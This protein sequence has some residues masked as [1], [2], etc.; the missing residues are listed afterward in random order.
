ML[1]IPAHAEGAG[2]SPLVARHSSYFR[3]GLGVPDHFLGIEELQV[4]QDV[5]LRGGFGPDP[6]ITRKSSSRWAHITDIHDINTYSSGLDGRCRGGLDDR[7]WGASSV[8][9]RVRADSRDRD[10]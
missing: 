1:E 4:G 9:G 2:A 7:F 6:E 8:R 10:P 3:L 5:F